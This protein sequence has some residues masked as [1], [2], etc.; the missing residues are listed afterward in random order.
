M[1]R[2]PPSPSL[3][4]AGRDVALIA[5]SRTPFLRSGGAY[6]HLMAHDLGRYAV[7]GLLQQCGIEPALV[8]RVIYGTVISDPRTSNLAREV[9]S[10]IDD[11]RGTIEYRVHLVGVL[12]TRTLTRAVARARG[13]S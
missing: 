11:M 12:V 9:A 4:A 1:T 2:S 10:P 6:R 7:S 3:P 8:E 5:G 13:E